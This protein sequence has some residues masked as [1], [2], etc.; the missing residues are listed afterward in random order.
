MVQGQAHANGNGG[1]IQ[2][3]AKALGRYAGKPK[4]QTHEFAYAGIM[5]CGNCSAAVTAEEK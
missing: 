5:T 3:S 4:S 1:G 2:R